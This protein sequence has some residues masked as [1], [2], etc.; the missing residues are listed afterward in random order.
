MVDSAA[1]AE[2]CCRQVF[3][4]LSNSELL[5]LGRVPQSTFGKCWCELLQ[6]GRPS[7]LS[8]GQS[9]EGYNDL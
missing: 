3:G 9:T 8:P 5:Q 6:A 2:L 1:Y 7:L 4:V